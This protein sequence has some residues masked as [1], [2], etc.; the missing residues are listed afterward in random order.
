M[1]GRK[2]REPTGDVFFVESEGF[3]RKANERIENRAP[4]DLIVVERVVKMA[5]ADG[6]FGQDQRAVARVPDGERPISD[7]FGKAI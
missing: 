2:H 5:R 6:V 3:T 7:E 4:S 1:H